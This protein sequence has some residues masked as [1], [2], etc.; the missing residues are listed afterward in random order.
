MCQST[1]ESCKWQHFNSSS[2]LP[3]TVE[4]SALFIQAPKLW[5]LHAFLLKI[6]IL[7]SRGV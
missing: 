4:L 2:D 7:G 3:W 5:E 1:Q 6:R